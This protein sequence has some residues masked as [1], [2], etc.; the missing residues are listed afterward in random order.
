MTIDD[1]FTRAIS[2]FTVAGHYHCTGVA[3]YRPLK[4]GE[5]PPRISGAL[6]A[7]RTASN[8]RVGRDNGVEFDNKCF[9]EPSPEILVVSPQRKFCKKEICFDKIKNTSKYIY[10]SLRFSAIHRRGRTKI[11]SLNPGVDAAPGVE[12]ATAAN[13]ECNLF[14][15]V[16]Y[17]SD[18][19]SR[20]PMCRLFRI[21]Y[22][23]I[24]IWEFI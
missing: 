12:N 13:H 14:W 4:F 2:I 17:H 15:L 5:S 7:H 19:I 20:S 3:R 11:R 22:A 9:V 21:H 18:R 24:F 1:N 6:R 8:P 16:V 23:C 10:H